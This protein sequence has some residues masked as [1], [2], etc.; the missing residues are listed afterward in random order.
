M[1]LIDRIWVWLFRRHHKEDFLMKMSGEDGTRILDVGCGNYSVLKVRRYCKGKHEIFYSG[2]DVGD[3]NITESSKDNADE[4]VIVAPEDLAEAILRWEDKEDM[5]IC[6]HNLEH[7]N[8]PEKV[9]TNIVRALKEGG[10]LY[11]SFP[12]EESVNFPKGFA[13]CLNYYDDLSHR[14]MII[15]SDVLETLKGCGM[16][17]IFQ[18]KNYRP[19]LLRIIGFLLWPISKHRK[20]ILPG[21]WEYFGFES[22]IW[23]VK[24]ESSQE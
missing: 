24:A 11:L 18:S 21:V 20:Q 8:E 19:I 7:R 22:V 12:S 4:Y 13:G 15:W 6:S 3:Y 10:K 16:D 23:A 1:H 9:L 5:V 14:E 17:I 2:L